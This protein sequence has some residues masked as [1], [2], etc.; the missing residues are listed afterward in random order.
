M[1]M[2]YFDNY[3]NR[4]F[5]LISFLRRSA[6]AILVMISVLL[7]LPE[8]G[9]T[10]GRTD[11][12]PALTDRILRL[13]ILAAGNDTA[14]QEIK[15][16]VRDAVLSVI[17][18]ALADVTTAAEAEAALLPLFDEITAAAER[19]LADSGVSYRATVEIT[20]EFFPIKQYGSLL[21]PPGEYRALRILLGEGRGK[22]WWCMLY[23]SLC[24]TE[25]I[26]ATIAE[27][28]KEELRGLLTEDEFHT[29]FSEED[30]KPLFR[31]RFADLFRKLK[32]FF[33]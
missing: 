7:L 12:S 4:K 32:K 25:G 6:A 22:N 16:H 14:S 8:R 29:L 5:V 15:L 27:E 1:I 10:A 23:P 18:E 3:F 17:R 28:E 13:H 2:Y 11:F 33:S 20:T 9:F 30:K 31:F 24:F 21:L 19:V 26:T